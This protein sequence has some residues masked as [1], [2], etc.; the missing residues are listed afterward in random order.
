M[1][2]TPGEAQPGIVWSEFCLLGVHHQDLSFS[3]CSSGSPCASSSPSSAWTGFA[4]PRVSASIA[5]PASSACVRS[6]RTGRSQSC[7]GA[8]QGAPRPHRRHPQALPVAINDTLAQ[9]C[10]SLGMQTWI[11]CQVAAE[12]TH[13][14]Q[15]ALLIRSVR[16][17]LLL[18]NLRL[19][20][21]LL[22]ALP[23]HA[24][25]VCPQR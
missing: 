9:R 15:L 5:P 3:C 14:F 20:Q 22:N 7:G 11:A 1:L 21:Y 16:R 2:K 23:K 8:H 12:R 6:S 24:L 10:S 19:R 13:L 17:E 4:K 18:R 25:L